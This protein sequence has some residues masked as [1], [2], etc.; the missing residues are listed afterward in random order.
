MIHMSHVASCVVKKK[1]H[2]IFGAL[3]ARVK[4]MFKERFMRHHLL[5]SFIYFFKQISV[6]VSEDFPPL[7]CIHA[8]CSAVIRQRQCNPYFPLQL[9]VC[10]L[11]NLPFISEHLSCVGD[12]V[13]SGANCLWLEV[14][15]IHHRCATSSNNQ[16]PFL[17]ILTEIGS[18]STPPPVSCKPCGV[19]LVGAVWV[20]VGR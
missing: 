16:I 1:C 9:S 14:T 13:A 10:Q 15:V 4:E 5:H 6:K 20:S 12:P 19:G 7:L 18:E 17:A 2:Q 11:F 8:T 3:A